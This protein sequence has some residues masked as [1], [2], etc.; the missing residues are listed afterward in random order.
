MAR[1]DAF[2]FLR[3]TFVFYHAFSL[4]V[5][6]RLNDG[7]RMLRSGWSKLRTWLGKA[8][9]MGPSIAVD[10]DPNPTYAGT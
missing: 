7:V 9:H 10:S 3:N 8:G 5:R 2:F 4:Y 1:L 6:A